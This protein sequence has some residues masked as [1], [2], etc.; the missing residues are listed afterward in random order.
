MDSI[1]VQLEKQT[2]KAGEAVRGRFRLKTTPQTPCRHIVSISLERVDG[3]TPRYLRRTVETAD[4]LGV[5]AIP[6]ALNEPAGEWTLI[7]SD[8]T[9][10]ARTATTFVLR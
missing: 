1:E 10:G 6:L 4:G 5:F 8:S 7:L 2:V 9:S 3:K